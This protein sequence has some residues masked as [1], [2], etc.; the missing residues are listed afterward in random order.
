MSIPIDRPATT[1]GL[2][3]WVMHRF[4]E[5]FGHEA[6]LKG[7][8][9]LRLFECPRSTTDI[10]YIF[11]PFSSKK[12]IEASIREVLA[13]LEDASID[14]KLHSKMIR[15]I[16]KLDAVSIQVEV[17]VASACSSE[18][19]A[20]AEF[21]R[22]VGQPSRVVRVQARSAALAHKLAAWNERRL[23]R[24]LYDIY[25][26]VARVGAQPDP[27]ELST[28]LARIQSRRPELKS[29]RSMT[30][31]EFAEHLRLAAEGLTQAGLEEELGPL[32]PEEELAGLDIRVRAVLARLSESLSA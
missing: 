20:T 27:D 26:L 5:R 23:L 15:A 8:M 31:T 25:F 2:F 12:E 30:R 13:E 11:S 19:M 18:A 10:D 14:L 1:D 3:L 4:S 32:L 9:A 7:G 24:D 29:T 28:R 17:S 16:V 22:G 6:I 21:A